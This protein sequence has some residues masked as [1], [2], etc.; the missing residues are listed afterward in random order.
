MHVEH[1]ELVQRE[2]VD[3]LLDLFHGEEVAGHVEDRAAIR[4]ARMVYD[5]ESLD[6]PVVTVES[7]VRFEVGREELPDRLSAAK[8][9]GWSIRDEANR[10][11]RHTPFIA[12][13][14][15]STTVRG[16][17][18]NDRSNRRRADWRDGDWEA[19]WA[20]Y[21]GCQHLADRAHLRVAG[22]DEDAGRSDDV[23]RCPRACD[24]RGWGGHELWYDRYRPWCWRWRGSL[25]RAS[26]NCPG[27]DEDTGR[28]PQLL[29]SSHHSVL[30]WLRAL[31][32][33]AHSG[34]VPG[35]RASNCM[36]INQPS[37]VNHDWENQLPRVAQIQE[38]IFEGLQR[39]RGR[40][41]PAR[42]FLHG[43]RSAPR[44]IRV[45]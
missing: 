14:S 43:K 29:S 39:L 25:T 31:R 32:D 4:E 35:D 34:K 3:V 42:G 45:Q 8:Q 20:T 28:I 18:Q 38:L 30:H 9:S 5:R 2:D 11:A 36:A 37:A 1:I 44:T 15:K 17:A 22:V 21:L 10:V 7:N 41:R 24:H 23:E 27:N 6:R 19:G 33:L 16:E 13:L 12:L 26:D 40:E